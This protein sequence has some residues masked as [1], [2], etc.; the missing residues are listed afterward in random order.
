MPAV[1]CTLSPTRN[2]C[3]VTVSSGA[4]I[5]ISVGLG[6]ARMRLGCAAAFA[7]TGFARLTGARRAAV[8]T[9]L[10]DGRRAAAFALLVDGRRAL[11]ARF[12]GARRD[13]LRLAAGFMSFI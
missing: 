4:M 12:A 11:L 8:L 13:A 10:V 6:R 9:L 5:G 7:G 2:L 3:A 1:R